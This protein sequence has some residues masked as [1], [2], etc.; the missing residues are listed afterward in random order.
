MKNLLIDNPK[1]LDEKGLFIAQHTVRTM[2]PLADLRLSQVF[3]WLSPI[4]KCFG[5]KA[6]AE[7]RT[8]L[9]QA[10]AIKIEKDEEEKHDNKIPHQSN[11]NYTNPNILS[12]S[13]KPK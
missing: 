1:K 6:T 3:G 12:P 10:D 5:R 11:T 8:N 9:A 2:H 7:E 13:L 4:E